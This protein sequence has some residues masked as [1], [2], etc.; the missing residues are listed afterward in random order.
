MSDISKIDPE[1]EFTKADAI[2]EKELGYKPLDFCYP[3]G[4]YSEESNEYISSKQNYHRIYTSRYMYSYRQN[5]KLIFGRCGISNDESFG[6][7]KAKLK[8]YF[9]VW[10]TIF[11]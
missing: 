8:G 1:L 9:N 6:V 10:R 3:F 2:F 4:N 7:F 5:G 11:G